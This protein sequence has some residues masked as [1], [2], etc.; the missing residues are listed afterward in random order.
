MEFRIGINLGD[1]VVDGD[2]LLG[3]GVNVAARVQLVAP[4]AGICLTGSVREQIEGN[5]TSASSRLAST[6]ENIPRPILIYRVDWATGPLTSAGVFAGALA[7][8]D[9]PSIAVLPF[10]NMSGD[11]EQDYFADGITEDLIS[12]LSHYRWFFVIARNSTFAYKGRAL[13]VKQIAA[14]WA[15]ATC[16]KAAFEKRRIESVQ[17]PS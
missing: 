17:P 12:A 10:V 9:K 5:M 3:D 6:R 1:V 13:D 7:L 2:D 11:R 14:N 15:S 16:S 4:T 8:P